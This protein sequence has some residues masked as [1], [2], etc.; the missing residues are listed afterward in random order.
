MTSIHSLTLDELHHVKYQLMQELARLHQQRELTPCLT[1][2]TH[3]L[4][5][6]IWRINNELDMRTSGR[7]WLN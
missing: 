4:A 6:H 2:R 5:G 7:V 3:I 1:D